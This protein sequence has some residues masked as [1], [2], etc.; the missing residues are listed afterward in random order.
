MREGRKAIGFTEANPYQVIRCLMRWRPKYVNW[1]FEPYGVAIEKE[2]AKSLGIRPVIYGMEPDYKSLPKQDK[3][4]FQSLGT[5]NVDWSQECE[6]RL[7]GDFDLKKVP[8]DRILFLAW[9]EQEAL[10][11]SSEPFNRAVALSGE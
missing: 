8:A 10:L 4:Y 7:A 1:N 11:L 5:A 9:R 2:C 3:P 6:W